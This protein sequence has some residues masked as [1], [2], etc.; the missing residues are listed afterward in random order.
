MTRLS[1]LEVERDGAGVTREG[2]QGAK[3]LFC[4][5]FQNPV[6]QFPA[7]FVAKKKVKDTRVNAWFCAYENYVNEVLLALSTLHH[8]HQNSKLGEYHV[9]ELEFC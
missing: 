5:V 3:P 7:V 8:E 2:C 1:Y 9:E 4:F 6:G